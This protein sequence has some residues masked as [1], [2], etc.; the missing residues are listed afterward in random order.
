[1]SGTKRRADQTKLVDLVMEGGGVKGIGLVGALDVLTAQGYTYRRIAG[2][3]AGAVTGSLLAAGMAPVQ[4]RQVMSQL[5]FQSFQ[6]EGFLDRLGPLGKGLSLAFEKGIYEGDYLVKW[7]TE[8][9]AEFKV[10]TFAD[11][12]LPDDQAQHLPP[13]Q[14]YKLVVMV[15]DVSRGKLIR[16]PWDYHKYGRDPDKQL[17]AEAVRASCS[18]PFYYEPVKMGKSFLVDGGVLSNF[19]VWIFEQGQHLHNTDVPTIGLKLSAKPEGLLARPEKDTSNTLAYAFSIISTMVSS[20]DQVHMDDPCT[21]RRTIFIDTFD[22]RA[23]EFGI[24]SRQQNRLFE[25]GQLA[26]QEFLAN[27]NLKKFI[28]M[29]PRG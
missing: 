17:V 25:N 2:T 3:S 22:L 21:Q 29:C 6:D 19:P 14:R 9:L 16:L 10:R 20:L 11:L 7:L 8:M 1:M 28:A 15:T 18:I 4:M 26:A 23:T 24:T 27:W 12:K 13:H 5:P